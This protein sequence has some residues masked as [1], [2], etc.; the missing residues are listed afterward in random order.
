M[1][2]ELNQI[3]KSNLE[4]NGQSQLIFK[5]ISLINSQHVK[6]YKELK[7]NH[8]DQVHNNNFPS[9]PAL[10]IQGCLGWKRICLT[11]YILLIE[12]PL[13]T[14]RGSMMASCRS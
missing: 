3:K 5:N 9:L 1:K 13:N 7:T 11:P 10:K 2:N 12:C 14:L 8:F 6:S 4:N